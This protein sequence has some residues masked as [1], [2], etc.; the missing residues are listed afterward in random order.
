MCLLSNERVRRVSRNTQGVSLLRTH[1]GNFSSGGS[2]SKCSDRRLNHGAYEWVRDKERGRE[3]I[4]MPGAEGGG[5]V[6]GCSQ[7]KVG[8]EN[9]VKRVK[10]KTSRK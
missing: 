5:A 8:V 10:G 4:P 6:G 7:T 3:G 1:S 2:D 9:T